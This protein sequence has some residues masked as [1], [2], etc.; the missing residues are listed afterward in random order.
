[1][2]AIVLQGGSLLDGLVSF[3]PHTQSNAQSMTSLACRE[4]NS[5]DAR[6]EIAI[7]IS[8]RGNLSN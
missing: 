2:C 5:R 4:V 3:G 6:Q 8:L 7:A 1:M